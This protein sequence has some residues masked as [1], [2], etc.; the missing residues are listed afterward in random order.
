MAS[1]NAPLVGCGIDDAIAYRLLRASSEREEAGD[2][3]PQRHWQS[4]GM[5]PL[6]PLN[7]VATC[8]LKRGRSGCSQ[9]LAKSGH[10]KSALYKTV[11][12]R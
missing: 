10:L 1:M 7:H 11:E 9:I 8:K 2:I 12:A 5:S 4:V 3:G 6:K